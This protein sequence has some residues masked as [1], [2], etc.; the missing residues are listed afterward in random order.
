MNS[1]F[2]FPIAGDLSGYDFNFCPEM[3]MHNVIRMCNEV[4]GVLP[5]IRLTTP[6]FS[7]GYIDVNPSMIGPKFSLFEEPIPLTRP[8]DDWYNRCYSSFVYINKKFREFDRDIQPVLSTDV[9]CLSHYYQQQSDK[10]REEG[11]TEF[12]RAHCTHFQTGIKL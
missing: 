9:D 1:V 4:N 8:I 7:D 12:L 11:S 2:Q 5:E 6:I 10:T 3:V